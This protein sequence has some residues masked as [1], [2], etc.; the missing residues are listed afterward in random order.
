MPSPRLAMGRLGGATHAAKA[1]WLANRAA[2]LGAALGDLPEL[3]R[4]IH[5]AFRTDAMAAR[6]AGAQDG[7]SAE[8]RPSPDGI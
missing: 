4:G 8:R 5:P 1:H 3:A 2:R 6:L 7:P